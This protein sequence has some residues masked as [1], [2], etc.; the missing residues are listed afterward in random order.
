MANNHVSDAQIVS[1]VTSRKGSSRAESHAMAFIARYRMELT[2]RSYETALR[3]F[4]GW[5]HEV[6]IDPL[7]ATW[8]EIELFARTLEQTGRKPGTVAAKL[9]VLAGF[10]KYA[11]ID[12][13]ITE[14]PMVHVNRP[15]IQRVS[16]TLGLTRTEFADVLTVADQMPPRDHALICL[17]GLNGL[18][19][20]EV[21]GIDIEHM[22]RWHGQ[23]T[24][25]I[26]RKAA[27]NRSCR[28]RPGRR[29]RSN[30]PKPTAGRGPCFLITLRR[31][32]WT[33]VER[34]GSSTAS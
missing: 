1:A 29:G 8:K 20:S 24:V 17:L 19:V 11:H 5:C 14:N 3:Q 21:V 12:R 2:R 28:W 23:R 30:S 34:L 16:T 6:G 7:Q 9:N 10:Y 27:S 13:L 15:Q 18:R 22:D 26:T 4:F 25:A 31:C 32:V 33:A